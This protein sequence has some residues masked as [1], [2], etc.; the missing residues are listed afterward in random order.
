M[1]CLAFSPSSSLPVYV[2]AVSL[3]VGDADLSSLA[4]LSA[5]LRHLTLDLTGM[6]YSCTD[7]STEL[8]GQQDR[9]QSL[10]APD[11]SSSPV[12]LMAWYGSVAS[13]PGIGGSSSLSE[14]LADLD[15]SLQS[16][17]TAQTC[18]RGRTMTHLQANWAL[19]LQSC[20]ENSVAS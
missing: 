18:S 2:Q 4:A 16:L 3:S 20:C 17:H 5:C 1:L 13:D 6:D 15:S 7:A 12:D 9:Q 19:W 10:P 14:Q 11:T 8:G